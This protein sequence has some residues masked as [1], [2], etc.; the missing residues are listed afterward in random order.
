[1]PGDGAAGHFGAVERIDM[2]AYTFGV[3]PLISGLER[4]GKSFQIKAIGLNRSPGEALLDTAEIE[5]R[6]HVDRNRRTGSHCANDTI[7]AKLFGRK[8]LWLPM[9]ALKEPFGGID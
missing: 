2:A 5:K 8:V 1:V 4:T 6:S 3:S 9:Q 7:F